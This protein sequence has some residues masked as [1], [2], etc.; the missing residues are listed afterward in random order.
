MESIIIICLVKEWKIERQINMKRNI[1]TTYH[2]SFFLD[3]LS[4]FNVFM[5]FS[6]VLFSEEFEN[7]NHFFQKKKN[8]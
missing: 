8:I 6:N 3:C 2:Y 7:N 5:H 1:T 4:I